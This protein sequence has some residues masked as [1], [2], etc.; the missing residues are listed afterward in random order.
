MN[1]IMTV[2]AHLCCRSRMS[3]IDIALECM[4][5]TTLCPDAAVDAHFLKILSQNCSHCEL[6]RQWSSCTETSLEVSHVALLSA[7]VY[8][9]GVLML[10]WLFGAS[11]VGACGNIP[12]V[13][14]RMV[15][16]SLVMSKYSI[17]QCRIAGCSSK[18]LPGSWC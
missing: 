18:S 10:G 16:C 6:S 12:D 7:L 14:V 2:A 3:R 1:L 8:S 11:I 4:S 15:V 5:K 17:I 13:I 9:N